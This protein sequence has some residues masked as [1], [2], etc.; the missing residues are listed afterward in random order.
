MD[1]RTTRRR[2][3]AAVDMRIMAETVP[4]ADIPN[5]Q[6]GDWRREA[7]GILHIRVAQEVGDDSALLIALHE[8]VEVA[9]CEKRGITCAEVD[10]W[11]ANFE[12][13]RKP[14]DTSEAGYAKGCPYSKEHH[15]ATLFE[16]AMAVE[17]GVDW[18]THEQKINSL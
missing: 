1:K 3:F 11:D 15:S 10:V 6:C 7:D 16:R 18:E 14:G 17:L 8:I 9:L 13:N 2:R 5:A 12:A 4:F